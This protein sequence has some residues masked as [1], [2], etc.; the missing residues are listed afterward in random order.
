MEEDRG[1]E[2]TGE[3]EVEEMKNMQ[4]QMNE[5]MNGWMD[6]WMIE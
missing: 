1:M 6:G 3:V 2:V 4:R 5:W